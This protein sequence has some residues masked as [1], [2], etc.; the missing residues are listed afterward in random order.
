MN[1]PSVSTVYST[2]KYNHVNNN[3]TRT[4]YHTQS[5]LGSVRPTDRCLHGSLI[6]AA[7]SLSVR[8]MLKM[9]TMWI[10]AI[11]RRRLP[12]IAATAANQEEPLTRALADVLTAAAMHVQ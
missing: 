3:S 6:K 1:Q 7:R 10:L 9:P 11:T 8:V 5:K 12:L 2:H 4:L